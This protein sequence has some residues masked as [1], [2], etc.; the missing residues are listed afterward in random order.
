MNRDLEIHR[1]KKCSAR[2][3]KKKEKDGNTKLESTV[4]LRGFYR[5]MGNGRKYLLARETIET[6]RANFQNIFVSNEVWKKQSE[7][8]CSSACC[9]REILS[10]IRETD[11]IRVMIT[12][13]FAIRL[14][15]FRLR[16][17]EV[18]GNKHTI[19]LRNENE[20]G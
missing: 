19:G 10:I 7:A 14:N 15:L 12:L 18:R 16:L 4:Y 20:R 6:I 1:Y 11:G 9:S 2:K 5:V 17:K 3:K 8:H 13:C